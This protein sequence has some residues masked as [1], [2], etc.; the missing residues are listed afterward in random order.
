MWFEGVIRDHL[1]L[2][3]P[4]Q[5][6]LIFQRRISRRTPG[7]FRT[8]VLNPG[9]DPTL[10]CCQ[11]QSLGENVPIVGTGF[12]LH[13]ESGRAPGAGA[14]NIASADAAMIGGWT[15]SVHHAYN[16]NIKTLF[17]G[18]GSQRNVRW[19]GDDSAPPSF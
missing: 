10:C 4:N 16:P 6:A 1:D 15:L 13:Y 18:D 5:I 11:T 19:S 14:N 8:R 12:H 17:L 2:G 3:R 7:K 9:V